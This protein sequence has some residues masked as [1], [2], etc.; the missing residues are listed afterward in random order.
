[1]LASMGFN[2]APPPGS[3]RA[4]RELYKKNI[5]PD[6][7]DLNDDND[8]MTKILVMGKIPNVTLLPGYGVADFPLESASRQGHVVKATLQIPLRPGEMSEVRRV[9]I[10]VK[11]IDLT[12]EVRN[13]I[14]ILE[15][16]RMEYH[17]EED[18]EFI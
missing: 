18:Q 4:R 17:N 1:M 11:V 3:F 14:H 8:E 12:G 15:K 16:E 6:L 5:D 10:N 2:K 9:M 7:I 13:D